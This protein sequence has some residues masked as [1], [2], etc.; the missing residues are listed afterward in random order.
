MAKE[1][2]SELSTEELTKKKK[3]TLFVSGIL[4]GAM[5]AAVLLTLNSGFSYLLIAPFAFSP[6]LFINYNI[7]SNINKELNS[8][9]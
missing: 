4:I 5:I 3:N 6:F 8:R 2:L 1:N 9:N 7:V